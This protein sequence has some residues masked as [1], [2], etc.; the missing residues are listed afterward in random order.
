MLICRIFVFISHVMQICF[1]CISVPLDIPCTNMLFDITIR[2]S[3]YLIV[4]YFQSFLF[5]FFAF[6]E[7]FALD[8]RNSLQYLHLCFKQYNI[9]QKETLQWNIWNIRPLFC[10]WNCIIILDTYTNACGIF[11]HTSATYGYFASE[12]KKMPLISHLMRL[13]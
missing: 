9:L 4:K 6:G 7:R 12:M 11:N 1:V 5:L 2:M 10:C 8:I 3:Y 13:Q